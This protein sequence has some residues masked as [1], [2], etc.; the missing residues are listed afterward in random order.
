MTEEQRDAARLRVVRGGRQPRE[1]LVATGVVEA[2]D[3]RAAARAPRDGGQRE[4]EVGLAGRVRPRGVE[5]L[6]AHEPDPFGARGDL[7]GRR[8]DVDPH[9]HAEMVE[10]AHGGLAASSVLLGVCQPARASVRHQRFAGADPYA[11][12]VVGRVDDDPLAGAHPVGHVPGHERERH[13]STA[14]KDRGM[15]RRHRGAPRLTLRPTR[16]DARH[17]AWR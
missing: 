3:D 9:G 12:L 5:E 14:R 11:R 15:G 2:R 13:T 1:G 17:R 4:G 7:L 6:C 10:R 8:A 16:D